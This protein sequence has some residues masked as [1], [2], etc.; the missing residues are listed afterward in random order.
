MK[1]GKPEG[2]ASISSCIFK[3][4][5]NNELYRRPVW[6][7]QGE[8]D[9]KCLGESSLEHGKD[10]HICL[11]DY[12]KAFWLSELATLMEMLEQAEVEKRDKDLIKNLY[13]EQAVVIRINRKDSEA[14][15][16]GRGVIQGCPMSP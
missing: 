3:G 13:M 5:Y 16:I 15:N 7:L 2:I 4:S 8:R 14:A 12:E 9:H 10:L 11:V 6:L 1:Q